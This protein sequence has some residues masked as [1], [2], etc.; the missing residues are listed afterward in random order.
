MIFSILLFLS[1][2]IFV[3]YSHNLLKKVC[4]NILIYCETIE[5]IFETSNL[6]SDNTLN[7]NN[8]HKN[9]I[10]LEVYIKSN[11]RLLSLYINHELLDSLDSEVL[12]LEQ[13]SKS[14]E[15]GES[16]SSLH[17]IISQT[18]NILS[19]QEINFENII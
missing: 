2:F 19:L 7:W 12:T 13:F 3:F 8:I 1:V 11:Y 17:K 6:N 5:E 15:I 18:K 10:E 9:S 16:L 4:N 14:Q